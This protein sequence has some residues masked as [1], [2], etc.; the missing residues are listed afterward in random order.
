MKHKITPSVEKKFVAETSEHS[1][2]WINQSKFPKGPKVVKPTNKKTLMLNFGDQCN[3]QPIVSSLSLSLSLSDLFGHSII[4][5]AKKL[6]PNS[7]TT[8]R[9]RPIYSLGQPKQVQLTYAFIK[10]VNLKLL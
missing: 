8:F 7:Q 9:G 5:I 10:S 6:M 2:F 3:K 4:F 1:T